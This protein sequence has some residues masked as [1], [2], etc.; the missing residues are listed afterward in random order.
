MIYVTKPEL[1]DV[2]EQVNQA[3]KRLEMALE[4]VKERLAELEKAR[5]VRKS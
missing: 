5:N 3:F 4:E 1:A 2:A